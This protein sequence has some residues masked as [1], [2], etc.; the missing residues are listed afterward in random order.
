MRHFS[1]NVSHGGIKIQKQAFVSF[2]QWTSTN[3]EPL[4]NYLLLECWWRIGRKGLEGVKDGPVSRASADVPVQNVFY[5][6]HGRLGVIVE[7]TGE[8]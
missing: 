8:R 2:Q 3:Q 7:Q 4:T 1:Q 6:G 5:L